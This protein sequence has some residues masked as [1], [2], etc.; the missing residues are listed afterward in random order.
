MKMKKRIS[1]TLSS[2]VLARVDRLAGSK[3]LR[4]AVIEQ[5]IQ[6][7]LRRQCSAADDAADLELI[8]A[9]PD[10]LHGEA[11]DVLEYVR[12]LTK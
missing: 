9:A 12:A 5:A 7:E 8:N 4:S 6:N 1:I 2:N 3:C 11:A 10:Q